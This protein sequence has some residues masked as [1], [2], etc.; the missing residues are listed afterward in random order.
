M[1]PSELLSPLRLCTALLVLSPLPAFLS[2]PLL[3]LL[4]QLLLGALE[5]SAALMFVPGL[6]CVL[7]A[8]EVSPAIA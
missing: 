6:V 4:P 8:A 7:W 1:C 3:L 5:T 2:L